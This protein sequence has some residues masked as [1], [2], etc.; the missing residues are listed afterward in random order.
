MM[1]MKKRMR[2]E[3]EEGEDMNS[4]SQKIITALLAKAVEYTVLDMS[5]NNVMVRF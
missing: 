5:L 3:E 1:M 2:E 4:K